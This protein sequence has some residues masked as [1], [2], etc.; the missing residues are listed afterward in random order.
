MVAILFRFQCVNVKT[1]LYPWQTTCIFAR[2]KF[3]LLEIKPNPRNYPKHYNDVI[4][5]TMPSQITSVSIFYSTI[6]SGTDKNTTAPRHWSL[7]G[8]LTGHRKMFPFD[9]VIMIWPPSLVIFRTIVHVKSLW[10]NDAIWWQS[11]GSTWAQVM[12]CCLTAPSHYL[13]QCWFIILKVSDVHLRV[14]SFEISQP[15]VTK[16]GFKIIFLRFY[17][18]VPG[19]NEL[20]VNNGS[21]WWPCPTCPRLSSESASDRSTQFFPHLCQ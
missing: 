15:S 19:A 11:S 4:M 3:H 9:D 12:A 18:N 5:S 8:E 17:W 13:D 10:P 21:H 6:C 1:C 14:I 7:W 20:R 16:I 2:S